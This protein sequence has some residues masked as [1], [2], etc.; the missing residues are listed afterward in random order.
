[1][2][3]YL[4][5]ALASDEQRSRVRLVLFCA[6]CAWIGEVGKC[7]RSSEFFSSRLEELP[8]SYQ[9]NGMPSYKHCLALRGEGRL[10]GPYDLTVVGV[11]KD[12]GSLALIFVVVNR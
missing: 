11:D 5:S 10:H 7:R 6:I 1:V 2:A 3:P 9:T 4:L 12:S 8:V